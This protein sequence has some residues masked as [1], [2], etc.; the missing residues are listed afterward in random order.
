M[1]T[2]F[3]K[4][5]EFLKRNNGQITTKDAAQFG[6]SAK[7]LSLM[8]QRGTLAKLGRGI[9]I[10]PNEFGDDLFALQFRY[11][12]GIFFKDTALFLHGM[13]DRTPDTYEMNFPINCSLQG[14]LSAPLKT[15]R[16]VQHLYGV[17]LI[18]VVGPG[19]NNLW[20]YD[21]E[22]TLCDILRKRDR[23]DVETIKQAMT[24]YARQSNK[25][26]DRL[27]E[28]AKLFKVRKEIET[29]MAILL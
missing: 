29:Y 26:L 15:Y 2:Q 19:G 20:T 4:V 3:D 9:Y 8:H 7:I 17:G 14:D 18:E 22:R 5:I 21:L 28:Y 27:I 6:V 23:S 12:R 24:A 25:N 11:S 1:L 16:Q 10:D 13:L